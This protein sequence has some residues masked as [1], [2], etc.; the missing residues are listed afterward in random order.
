M[1]ATEP[2][3]ATLHGAVAHVLT[4]QINH[5]APELEFDE[6]GHH[7]ETGEMVYD[8]SPAVIAAAIKFLKDNQITCEVESN[9]EMSSL[10]D[11]LS[12]KQ[13]HSRTSPQEAA[14][15]LVDKAI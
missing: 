2:K 13:K 14:L 4:E 8:C 6:N 11:A 3:L 10:R 15:Q 7:V 5:R 12:K 9:Q 1:K